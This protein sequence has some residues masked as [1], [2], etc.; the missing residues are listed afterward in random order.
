MIVDFKNSKPFIEFGFN[1]AEKTVA[2][3]EVFKVWVIG[4]YNNSLYT[5][6]LSCSGIP[7]VEKISDFEYNVS[8]AI[9]GQYEI[10]LNLVHGFQKKKSIISNTI[11]ITVE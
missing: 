3:G 4:Q 5:Y 9:P 11:T 6:Q 1:E 8:Y 7:D 10:T 2:P